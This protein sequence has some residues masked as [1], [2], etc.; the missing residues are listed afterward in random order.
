MDEEDEGLDL[1]AEGTSQLNLYC[2]W[3]SLWFGG[4]EDFFM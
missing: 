1:A 4:K 3:G 2:S